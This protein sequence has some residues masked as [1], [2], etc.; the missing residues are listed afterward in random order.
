M[1]ISGAALALRAG[2]LE[3]AL[4]WAMDH[5]SRLRRVG[6]SL[7]LE[8]RV[9]QFL[10]LVVLGRRPEAIAHAELHLAPAAMAAQCPAPT[11]EPA[12]GA[13]DQGVAAPAHRPGRDVLRRLQQ[14]MGVLAFSRPAS[15]GVPDVERL[16][17]PERA[18][19][20]AT[21]FEKDASEAAALL[22]SSS[23]RAAL[24]AG[25]AALRSPFDAC[26]GSARGGAPSVEGTRRRWM[27]RTALSSAAAAS[28]AAAARAAGHDSARAT[29]EGAIAAVNAARRTQRDP[30]AR[31]SLAAEAHTGT[32][33]AV[34]GVAHTPRAAL[35]ESL[36]TVRETAPLLR[37]EGSRLLCSLTGLPL[38]GAGEAGAGRRGRAPALDAA[39][40]RNRTSPS[41]SKGSAGMTESPALAALRRAASALDCSFPELPAAED[42][43]DADGRQRRRAPPGRRSA[44]VAAEGVAVGQVGEAGWP[45]RP[46]ALPC[47]RVVG[48]AALLVHEVERRRQELGD[49]A[50][51]AEARRERDARLPEQAVPA[52]DDAERLREAAA[53]LHSAEL[54]ARNDDAAKGLESLARFRC[55]FTGAWI[56]SRDLRRVY[57]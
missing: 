48:D 47:S 34:E 18:A 45:G 25:A 40:A 14:L 55:P 28:A 5:A 41:A 4:Q 56:T 51:E 49:R 42:G 46:V 30:S 9:A 57:L 53:E 23:L 38:G 21:L 36:W 10:E 20:L 7:L 43:G 12:G 15:C 33:S 44:S 16:F 35:A 13:P 1:S 24:F 11:L 22:P 31:A 32:R 26:P 29:R 19:E 39:P 27:E 2:N 52:F 3:P 17:R 50:S 54:A 6:S 8:L 37:R